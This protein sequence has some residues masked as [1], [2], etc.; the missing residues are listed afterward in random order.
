[1]H[2]G[3]RIIKIGIDKTMDIEELRK[4][5]DGLNLTDTQILTAKG[6]GITKDQLMELKINIE[7][8][9][10]DFRSM[11]EQIINAFSPVIKSN[12]LELK[13]LMDNINKIQIKSIAIPTKSKKGKKLKCWEKKK[14]YQ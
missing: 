4:E 11:F 9:I 8:M 12:A 13:K 3:K 10:I 14:F 1:M 6:V 2:T 7:K 5:Y